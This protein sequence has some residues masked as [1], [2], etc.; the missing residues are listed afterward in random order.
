MIRA[1][2][3]KC[4]ECVKEGNKADQWI[5]NK[6]HQLCQRHNNI[7]LHPK[8]V[9]RPTQIKKRRFS[10]TF[11]YCMRWGFEREMD[12]FIHIWQTRP[13]V[14]YLSG[15]PINSFHP[16]NFMHVLAKGLNKYP[17]Y[18]LNP[19]NVVLGLR[20]EHNMIDQGTEEQ[21]EKYK[22]ECP[23]FAIEAYRIKEQKLKEFYNN[24]FL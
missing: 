10:T 14:S 4:L 6:K 15:K 12:M 18:R 23:N 5:V 2:K 8:G 24:E 1:K 22:K 7:R 11:E 16:A 21:I 3:G 19:D 20:I 17:Q 9:K 13:H